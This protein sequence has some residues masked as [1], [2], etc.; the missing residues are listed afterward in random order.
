MVE[1]LFKIH[2]IIKIIQ[3]L[4]IIV[5]FEH[6]NFII[7]KIIQTHLIKEIIQEHLIFDIIQVHLI[8]DIIQAYSIV[9][10]IV[11]A[12]PKIILTIIPFRII[13]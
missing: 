4:L 8:K 9:E 13:Q 2:I 3:N 11:L 6:L 12:E 1:L 10:I 5:K 7:V